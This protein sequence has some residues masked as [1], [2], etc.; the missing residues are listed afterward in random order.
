MSLG[1]SRW[2]WVLGAACILL[3][4]IITAVSLTGWMEFPFVSSGPLAPPV[5][6]DGDKIIT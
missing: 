5:G 4:L 6:G 1:C 3:Q 2:V